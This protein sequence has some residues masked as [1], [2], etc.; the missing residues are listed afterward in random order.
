MNV[1]RWFRFPEKSDDAH[2]AGYI[3]D[4]E[5]VMMRRMGLRHVRLCIAPQLVMTPVTG[6][7]KEHEWGYIEKAIQR[8]LDH[9]LAVVV[10]M[11]NENRRDEADPAWESQFQ[12]FWGIAAKRLSHFDPNR[13]F[14]EI[15]NEPVFDHK[16]SEWKVLLPRLA[17][18]I[19]A[20]AP[21]HTI[22]AS[23]ANW[24]GIYGLQQLEPLADRNVVYSF[25]T[26]DP[27]PFTHQAA[28]WAGE[29]VKPLRG[30]PYPSSP[31]AVAPLLPGL[32]EESRKMLENYGRERWNREKMTENFRQAI[33]WGRKNKAPLYCGE[34]GVFPVAAKPEHRA[35]WFR[36]FGSVLKQ[37]RVGWASWGWDEGFGFDRH[38][39][40]G[41][42]VVDPVVAKALGMNLP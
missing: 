31:E 33:D 1:C 6:A 40:G 16:E 15:V 11:H 23:G 8:F 39:V 36:D 30:V 5:M 28:T 35:N 29:A 22:I 17:K 13:V 7:P 12:N 14:L 42:I 27:F 38:R 32:P 34:F 3:G 10:D 20:S 24:G 41:K 2:W 19:R 25:H 37:N 26:Y 21:R 18:T 4:D 9:G